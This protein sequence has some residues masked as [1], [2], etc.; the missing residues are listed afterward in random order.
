[1]IGFT[2]K[3]FKPFQKDACQATLEMEKEEDAT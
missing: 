1:L 3:R 2:R